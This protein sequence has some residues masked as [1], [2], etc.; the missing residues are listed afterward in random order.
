M[1]KGVMKLAACCMAGVMVMGNTGVTTLAVGLDASLAGMGAAVVEGQKAKEEA[2]V[3]KVAPTEYDTIAIAQVDEYVNIRDAASTEGS[4]VGKLY[5][6]CKA[7]ILGQTDGWYLIQSGNVTGYVKAEYFAT[8]D[9]AEAL[10]AEVGTE[11]ATVKEGT[12]TLMVRSS[13]DSNSDAISMVGDYETLQVIEDEGD[14][15]KVSVDDD[16]VGY[17]SKEYVDCDTEY[18]EAESVEEV[19]ARQDAIADAY[20]RAVEMQEAAYAAMNAA[21]GAEAAYAASEANAALAEAMM[22]ANEQEFDYEAQDLAAEIAAVAQDTTV[23]AVWAQEAED[24]YERIAA[25]EAAAAAA[26][27][28]ADAAAQQAADEAAAAAASSQASAENQEAVAEQKEAEAAQ[29][30]QEA[31]DAQEAANENWSEES[32]AVADEAAAAA[33]QAA[34]EAEAARQQAE[35]EAQ[36]AAE[37]EA[38]RQQAEAEAA[39][40]QQQQQDTSSE[41]TSSQDTSSSESSASSSSSSLR[42]SVVNYALQ[43]VGNPYVYGGNS[44]TN[45]IDCSGFTQQILA[46]VGVSIPR[47]AASQSGT[48]TAVS[49]DAIQPGDL[50]FYSSGSGIG[51]VS[52]YIGNGQVVHASN[53]TSGIIVSSIGYRTPCCARSYF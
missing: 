17:V 51:H 41:D 27:A 35:A 1:K 46:H 15:V 12:E 29:A 21:D 26:Q 30:W 43:F 44:L 13:A 37:A 8:G 3:V 25:E 32:Q 52:M 14:W 9:A 23:A 24:E 28:A 34:A 31:V 11:V 49:L 50:L 36:A 5:N 45:G 40:Q 53:P 22:L 39:Q 48:G 6:N 10:A 47:T 33:M 7:E 18:K 20:E 4:V 19:A 2:G 38:A 42:Q 16:V